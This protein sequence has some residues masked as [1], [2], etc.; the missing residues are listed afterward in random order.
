MT[1]KTEELIPIR[2]RV[3][4]LVKEGVI[5]RT[6]LAKTLNDEGY[7]NSIGA[8]ITPF[9][10]RFYMKSPGTVKKTKTKAPKDPVGVKKV[11]IHDEDLKVVVR[12]KLARGS[13]FA[14]P[15]TLAIVG[16]ILNEKSLSPKVKITTA[17]L[18]IESQ[19]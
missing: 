13:R 7:R 10:T 17:L 3:A 11:P 1:T 2:D 5:D 14:G 15:S 18:I 6:A 12:P 16:R 9:S 4:A 8:K 19:G